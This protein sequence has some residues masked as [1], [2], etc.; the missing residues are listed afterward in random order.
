MIELMEN[1]VEE[2]AP[3]AP[4]AKN[5]KKPAPRPKQAT[6]GPVYLLLSSNGKYRELRE[7][8]LLAEAGNILRDPSLRLVKGQFMVPQISFKLAEE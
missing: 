6:T 1:A 4:S 7:S 3:S 2:T 5:K 8:E